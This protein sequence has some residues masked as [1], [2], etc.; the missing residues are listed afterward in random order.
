MFQ[1]EKTYTVLLIITTIL[2]QL[3]P[4]IPIYLSALIID[5]LITN[6]DKKG[7]SFLY[8]SQ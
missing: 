7:F 3:I 2:K 1:L 4:Y 5:E 6:P 8:P